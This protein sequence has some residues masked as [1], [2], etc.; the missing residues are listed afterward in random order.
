MHKARLESDC[1]HVI[2]YGKEKWAVLPEGAKRSYKIYQDKMA[3][4]SSAKELAR[5]KSIS[6]VT[7]HRRDGM[8][9][10]TFGIKHK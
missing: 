4:V 3:A 2:A 10:R 6:S 8:L 5:K 7:L 1:V 9:D